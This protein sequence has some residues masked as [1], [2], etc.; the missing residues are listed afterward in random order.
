MEIDMKEVMNSYMNYIIQL[1]DTPEEEFSELGKNMKLW[2]DNF[3]DEEFES[4]R[5]YRNN[6]PTEEE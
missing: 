3:S 6:L 4:L 2:A 5:D 1:R